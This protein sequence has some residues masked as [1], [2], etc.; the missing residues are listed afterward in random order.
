MLASVFMDLQQ[1]G[2][3]H[4]AVK[5]VLAIQRNTAPNRF[6]RVIAEGL[7]AVKLALELGLRID[8]FFYCPE[9]VRSDDAN[10]QASKLLA[11]ARRSFQVS[12]KTFNRISE[13]GE[14]DGLLAL[15]EMPQWEPEEIKLG[16][17]ALVLVTDGVEIPGNLGTLIRT[18]D[19]CKADLLIMTNRRTRMSHP[20]VFR[21]S[22][23]MSLVV[24]H[25]EFEE[26]ADAIAWL[27]RNRFAHISGRYR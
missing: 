17:S 5:D 22:Q 15:V 9:L 13:R 21:G 4:P 26:T 2:T 23:G 19:A 11:R 24:P 27:K 25:V 14:K 3:S 6:I 12:E 1:I 7:W 10:T 16:N 20:K 18:L 8:K